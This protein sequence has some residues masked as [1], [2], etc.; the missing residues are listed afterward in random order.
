MNP[1]SLRILEFDKILA[2]L[3][4][5]TSFSAGRELALALRPSTD[6]D[7]VRRRLRETTEARDLLDHKGGVT[8]G[9]A[10]DVRPLA[11]RAAMGA[12]L[13]AQEL[14]DVRD[15]LA[16]GRSLRRTITRGA[17]LW[18][19]L[20]RTAGGIEE[21]DNLVAAIEGCI[22]DHG[23]V[24]DSASPALASIRRE[25]RITQ[26][27]LRARLE[28]LIASPDIRQ[29]LQEPI[30][31]QREGRYVIPLKAEFKGRI[32]GLIHDTSA[33][34]ATLF[35]EPLA[36][37]ELGNRYRELQLEEQHEIERI[38]R[39]LSAQ[40]AAKADAITRTVEALARLDLALAKAKYSEAIR[41]VEP[42][43]LKET[44]TGKEPQVTK[45]AEGT[46]VI[47]EHSVSSPELPG[48]A[49]SSLKFLQARHPLLPPEIVVPIDI[50][51]GE[52]FRVLVITG[53]NTGGKT[54]ALKTTGLL[55]LMAQAGLHI[56]A[57]EGSRLTVFS[58]VYADI[59]DEQSIEQSL[60]TFSSHMTNIVEILR[61]ADNR[62]LVL[63]DEIGAGTD[64]TEGSA[65]ARAILSYLLDRDI[66]TL[67]ITHYNELKVFAHTTP[68]VENA[69]VEFDVETL[70]PT[71]ELTIGLPGRSNAFA[72]AQRLGLPSPVLERARE[73][74]SESELAMEDM[75]AEIKVARE[76]AVAARRSV[77]ATRQEVQSLE[78]E[79]RAQLAALEEERRRVIN[80]A[81]RQAREE[82]EAFR[83]ELR[84]LRR[85]LAAAVE[86]RE[87]ASQVAAEVEALAEG[88]QPVKPPEGPVGPLAVGDWVQV[89]TLK[90]QGEITHLE[91]DQAEV[92]LGPLRARVPLSELEPA[93]RPAR[94]G[95]LQPASPVEVHTTEPL[96]P[97]LELSLRGLPVEDALPRL[98]KH[99]NDAYLSGLPWVRIVHGK[100]TGALRRAVRQFLDEHPLVVGYR[101]GDLEEGGDGVT[102]AE[103]ASKH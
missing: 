19:L 77:E 22:N 95:R 9:G 103:L 23:E 85:K 40:V 101:S 47:L 91:G 68:G 100:G 15:T 39:E 28:R 63:L 50:H 53:P 3:A 102:I 41:G 6:F 83:R 43:L 90:A 89:T 49:R 74:M 67:A 26:D 35:I 86:T 16:S 12:V 33:S 81:R 57:A 44:R 65:L 30:I 5:Y 54:V 48:V 76:D 2:R 24:V 70:A 64:P 58:G 20:A 93:D 61:A 36:V 71:F 45:G 99:L 37:V 96:R 72:I 55:T 34:G 32:P 60:S 46:G 18:P 62:S 17:E 10:H 59:G 69:C 51:V 79:L 42:V 13:T 11:K 1:K 98:D 75:L 82:L 4:N 84:R 56:P 78:R 52:E 8:V 97:R 25:L 14:L 73:W 31:T 38:L 87:L 27:R 94:A 66:T 7:E 21:C 29:F 88:V 80:E 92:Q